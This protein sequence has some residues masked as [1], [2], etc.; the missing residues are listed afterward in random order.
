MELFDPTKPLVTYVGALSIFSFSLLWL[1]YWDDENNRGNRVRKIRFEPVIAVLS[2]FI[3]QILVLDLRTIDF[4]LS[5]FIAVITLAVIVLVMYERWTEIGRWRVSTV[6]AFLVFGNTLLFWNNYQNSINGVTIKAMLHSEVSSEPTTHDLLSERWEQQAV[7]QFKEKFGATVEIESGDPHSDKRLQE[8]LDE[9]ASENK[10][11]I[12]VFAIDVISTGTLAEY[13]ENLSPLFKENLTGFFDAIIRNNTIQNDVSNSKLVALP[14]FMDIGLLFYRPTLLE[15]YGYDE[16]PKTWDELEEMAKEIQRGERDQE[17][18]RNFWGFVW[19]GDAYEGLTCNA[20]EWQFSHS[21]GTIVDTNKNV[22]IKALSVT[23]FEQ[24][25]NWIWTDQISPPDVIEYDEGQTLKIWLRGNAAFMRHWPYAYRASQEENS[26]IH[27]DIA[28]TLLPKGNDESGRH[29]STL[30][31]WQLMINAKAK[32]KEKRAAIKFVEFLTSRE[33]QKS[34]VIETGKLPTLI[35]LY[36][37]P[38]VKSSLKFI[39]ENEQLNP[40][41]LNRIIVK[42]P[43]I[44]TGKQYPEISKNYFNRV[45]EILEDRDNSKNTHKIVE[46]LRSGIQQIL[47]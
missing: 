17:G 30:G 8:I 23:A 39:A 4:E 2:A 10:T 15:K 1:L 40:S 38:D 45:H 19:Q 44:Y 27:G 41:S 3:A 7:A 31:G 24:A 16:P 28:V 42:R 25:K 47:Q 37:D 34:L 13:A 6:V 14:W 18:K 26:I 33:M 20:L 35:D 46:G 9:L 21:G 22:D 12:D 5:L 36:D 32:G 11:D 29:A 43:S